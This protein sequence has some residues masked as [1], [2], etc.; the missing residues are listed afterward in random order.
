MKSI[1]HPDGCPEIVLSKGELNTLRKGWAILEEL[2]HR[3][4]NGAMIGS[5]PFSPEQLLVTAEDVRA[6]LIAADNAK[7]EK[8]QEG[9]V[10]EQLKPAEPQ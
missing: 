9:V 5:T 8:K 1:L 6:L 4:R 7:A 3:G 10:P 2:S